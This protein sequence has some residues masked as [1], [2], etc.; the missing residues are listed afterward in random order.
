MRGATHLERAQSPDTPAEADPAPQHHLEQ[1]LIA[2]RIEDDIG[3]TTGALDESLLNVSYFYRRSIEEWVDRALKL[4]QIGLTLFLGLILA[5]IMY[6]VLS[7]IYDMFGKL[8]F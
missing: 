1:H 3:E 6:A 5:F 4:L 7:P 2:A 8:S